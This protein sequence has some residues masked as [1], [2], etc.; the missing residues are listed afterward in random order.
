MPNFFENLLKG[1]TSTFNTLAVI[2][3]MTYAFLT[4]F[5]AI[6]VTTNPSSL[7]PESLALVK[8]ILDKLKDIVLVILGAFIQKRMNETLGKTN[9]G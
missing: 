2:L 5:I 6:Y 4:T 9:E 1:R 8:D 3:G 7:K